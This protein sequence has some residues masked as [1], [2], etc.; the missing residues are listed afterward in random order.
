MLMTELREH[1]EGKFDVQR[2]FKTKLG[3]LCHRFVPLIQGQ[4]SIGVGVK[5]LPQFI[6]HVHLKDRWYAY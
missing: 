5:G 4:V 2:T 6:M 1:F 3:Q